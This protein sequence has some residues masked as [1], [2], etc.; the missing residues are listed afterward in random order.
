MTNQFIFGEKKFHLHPVNI[1][2]HQLKTMTLVY[3]TVV[4]GGSKCGALRPYFSLSALFDLNMLESCS[5]F[6]FTSGVPTALALRDEQ[7]T[8]YIKATTLSS[9]LQYIGIYTIDIL[10]SYHSNK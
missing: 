6:G 8:K 7:T 9:I 5:R 2:L 10:G 3:C 4:V 1:I